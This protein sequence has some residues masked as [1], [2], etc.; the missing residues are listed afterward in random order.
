MPVYIISRR[1]VVSYAIY[2]NQNWYQKMNR[3]CLLFCVLYKLTTKLLTVNCTFPKMPINV[4]YVKYI[5][6]SCIFVD[7]LTMPLGESRTHTTCDVISVWRHSCGCGRGD[8]LKDV[9]AWCIPCYLYYILLSCTKENILL[10][11]KFH[12]CAFNK[13]HK[14]IQFCSVF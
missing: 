4:Q 10:I 1:I 3:N 13:I 7:S 12:L 8:F 2:T 5:N 6:K 9:G 14:T 11:T